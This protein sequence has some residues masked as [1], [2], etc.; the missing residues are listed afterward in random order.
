MASP[1]RGRLSERQLALAQ[2]FFRQQRGGFFLTGGAVLAGW[3]LEHRTTEDLDLFT[4][5]KDALTEGEQSLRRAAE[6]VGATLEAITTTP[7]FRRF[8]V[9]FSDETVK[10]DLVRDHAP[11]LLPKVERDGVM[12][13]SAAEIF[14]NKLCTL[15]ERSEIRDLVDVMMLEQRGHRA[16]AALA[17][18]QKKDAGVT[19]GTLAWLLKSF[20]IPSEIPGAVTREQVEAFRADLERRLL[21]LARA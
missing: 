1:R 12:T 20:V 8:V 15:V 3:E 5:R 14:A 19:A 2:A 18:A 10:V 9:R 17:D 4:D 6:D 7:D 16:E 21:L 13:D 11:Q